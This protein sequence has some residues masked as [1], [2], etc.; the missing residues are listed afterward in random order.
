[1]NTRRNIQSVFVIGFILFLF[2][3]GFSV[4]LSAEEY[5]IAE[6]EYSI[7]GASRDWAI[8]DRLDIAIGQV[9]PDERSLLL[10]LADQQQILINQRVLHDASILYFLMP[11]DPVTQ[12]REVLV[13]IRTR[14]TW[15]YFLLPYFRYDSNTGLLLSLRGRNYNFFGTLQELELN[16]DYER[17]EDNTDQFSVSANFSIPVKI[18]EQRYR[19]AM[20]QEVTVEGDEVAYSL[21]VGTGLDF[22]WLQQTWIASYTQSYRYDSADEYDDTSYFG[23]RVDLETGINT[24]VSVPTFG[25]LS[26]APDLYTGTNYKPG[27]ISDDRDGLSV[28]FDHTLNA[29]RTNWFGNYRNGRTLRIT[30]GNSFETFDRRW[31]NDL[32]F[33]VIGHKAWSKAGLSA[34]FTSFYLLSGAEDDQD[35]AADDIRGVL[36]DRMNGDLGVFLN[37]DAVRTIWTLKPLFEAQTGVFLDTAL[38]R[39]LR[40]DFSDES[41]FDMERDLRFGGGIEVVGFPLFARSLFIRASYGVDLRDVADGASPLSSEVRELFFGLGHHY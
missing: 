37:L 39:D 27:G 3:L 36:N 40:G 24:G 32:R 5:R 2:S 38:V 7:K 18:R 8:E 26:W 22:P 4:S 1:M 25:D 31:S 19:L 6:I 17:T 41:A 20:D 16:L 23:S 33:S 15:N 14:D 10:F 35:N 13:R 34:R 29:G 11:D 9:F 28:G 21:D 30:N 12:T